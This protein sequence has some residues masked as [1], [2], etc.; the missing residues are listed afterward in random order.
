M[1]KFSTLISKALIGSLL[2]AVISCPDEVNPPEQ[3]PAGVRLKSHS[4]PTLP[5]ENGLRPLEGLNANIRIEWTPLEN[6]QNNIIAEYLIFRA[7]GADSPFVQIGNRIVDFAEEDSF[8]VDEDL[9]E[10]VTYSYMVI[11]RNSKNKLSDTSLYFGNDEF[12]KSI[13][14]GQ[15]VDY[16]FV[17]SAH[18][19]PTFQWCMGS[20]PPIKYLVKLA[21]S[22]GQI[23]WIAEKQTGVFDAECLINTD[24]YEYLTFHNTS[25]NANDSLKVK[26][27]TNVTVHYINPSHFDGG[28]L[29]KNISYQWR[30]DCIFDGAESKSRWSNYSAIKDYTYPN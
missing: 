7:N 4:D 13:R 6:D 12:I 23:I 19:K 1:K 11:A 15:K 30:V 5:N 16:M 26:T 24:N 8:F 2:F 10:D 3:R 28:R 18:T 27:T 21:T 17:D 29:R 14:L 25:Y 9:S 20:Q 22:T